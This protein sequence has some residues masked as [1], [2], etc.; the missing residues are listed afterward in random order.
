MS[1]KRH[2]KMAAIGQLFIRS[3]KSVFMLSVKRVD[4]KHKASKTH[5]EHLIS[6][7]L[8]F[9]LSKFTFAIE[10]LELLRVVCQ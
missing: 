2:L 7:H 9:F 8:P 4:D 5:N 1:S 3:Y 10:I 6:Q